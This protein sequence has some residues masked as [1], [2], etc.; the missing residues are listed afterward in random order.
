[1]NRHR[2]FVFA[3]RSRTLQLR[4][5]C[6]ALYQGV[7]AQKLYYGGLPAER[8]MERLIELSLYVEEKL[9]TARRVG[10][11]SRATASGR[12][13]LFH[14]PH[15]STTTSPHITALVVA[16]SAPRTAAPQYRGR[17]SPC[18]RC[19]PSYAAAWRHVS[20]LFAPLRPDIAPR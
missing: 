1:V 7:G 12:Q 15:V 8:L 9:K 6:A 4:L 2:D 13:F 20:L 11:D 5:S 14:A 16:L 18:F 17:R 19:C 3:T 10:T